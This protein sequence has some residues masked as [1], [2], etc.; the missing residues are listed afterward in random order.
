MGSHSDSPA[1]EPALEYAK[2]VVDLRGMIQQFE[3]ARGVASGNPSAGTPYGVDAVRTYPPF[4]GNPSLVTIDRNVTYI[5]HGDAEG[6]LF[7]VYSLGVYSKP[8]FQDRGQM[9][10]DETSEFALRLPPPPAELHRMVHINHNGVDSVWLAAPMEPLDASPYIVYFVKS[11]PIVSAF[12]P[13][14]ALQ[15]DRPLDGIFIRFVPP[16]GDHADL[17]M[18][19]DDHTYFTNALQQLG[20]AQILAQSP[21]RVLPSAFKEVGNMDSDFEV[22]GYRSEWEFQG[23]VI[24][25]P[26]GPAHPGVRPWSQRGPSPA[27][28]AYN[29]P[30]VGGT[31]L[32]WYQESVRPTTFVAHSSSDKSCQFFVTSIALQGLRSINGSKSGTAFLIPSTSAASIASLTSLNLNNGYRNGTPT[33]VLLTSLNMNFLNGNS[34]VSH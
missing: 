34:Q 16:A 22:L 7:T 20:M 27:T 15:S 5:R 4:F 3:S 1:D 13:P 32:L 33:F 9:R 25:V 14:A 21:V 11:A 12:R 28:P 29:T 2:Q 30:M 17:R 23:P 6:P 26:L 24:E 18:S 8:I 10:V 31:D 19:V